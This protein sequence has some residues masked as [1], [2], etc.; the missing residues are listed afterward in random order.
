MSPR[1]NKPRQ[2]TIAQ[3]E[4]EHNYFSFS[5]IFSGFYRAGRF[6]FV[7]HDHHRVCVKELDL[8]VY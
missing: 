2:P 5:D 1:V 7:D 4:A 6:D 3:D 8:V